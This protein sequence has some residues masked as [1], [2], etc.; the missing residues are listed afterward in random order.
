MK[1]VCRVR[2][3]STLVGQSG[4]PRPLTYHDWPMASPTPSHELSST[5]VV[6]AIIDTTTSELNRLD[7]RPY[8]IWLLSSTHGPK[9]EIYT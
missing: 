9:K 2:L 8:T 6:P 5:D 1:N 4:I 3:N 7:G